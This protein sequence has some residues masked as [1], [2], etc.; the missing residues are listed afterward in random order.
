MYDIL[1]D[2]VIP[3]VLFSTKKNVGW[4]AILSLN[5]HSF[6]PPIPT[7]HGFPIIDTTHLELT[8]FGF[9]L[10]VSVCTEMDDREVEKGRAIG[11]V[12]AAINKY[13]GKINLQGP[14][15]MHKPEKG[16]SD[17]ERRTS[18]ASELHLAKKK[19]DKL[20]DD[21]KIVQSEI[22][23]AELQLLQ[24]KKV[25]RALTARIEGSKSK[26]K[27]Q[28]KAKSIGVEDC[29]YED[30][31]REVEALKRELS[32]LKLDMARA[33]EE[34]L[35]A[36]EEAEAANLTLESYVSSAEQLR[37]EIEEAND[38]EVL[39]ELAKIQARKE[40]AETEAQREEY[41]GKFSSQ[42]EE[43]RK[44]ICI[45]REEMERIKDLKEKLADTNSDIEVLQNELNLIREID[46]RV[47]R[48]NTETQPVNPEE[49]E[50]VKKEL[51]SIQGSAFL[52][53]TIMDA[54]RND[55]KEVMEEKDRMLKLEEETKN[56]I[57]NLNSELHRARDKLAAVSAS[58]AKENLML[59]N[60]S[61]ALED[62]QKEKEGALKE[63]QSAQEEIAS[64]RMEIQKTENG[65][66]VTEEK[67]SAAMQE[68]ASVKSAEAKALKKLKAVAEKAAKSRASASKKKS[69]I[70]ISKFEYN[71]LTGG[72]LAAQEV[73]E[74]KV[75]AAH[76]WAEAMRASEREMNVE[77]ELAEK[78]VRELL[79]QEEQ[80]IQRKEKSL[81]TKES[82]EG[83]VQNL[84]KQSRKSM[85]ENSYSLT[86]ARQAKFRR[87][88]GSPT[89]RR[90][91]TPGSF[92]M[93]RRRM[94]IFKLAKC[95]ASR[96]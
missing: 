25:A 64:V 1:E 16:V 19:I 26:A 33:L 54:I 30:V 75:A 21:A 91:S 49:L 43:T 24:A 38:E 70:A 87:S 48:K 12:K 37:R 46:G 92:T 74:K 66:D 55:L 2:N 36:E 7:A 65:T 29:D 34:K 71:Y 23:Q 22:S 17:S 47:E 82:V 59:S 6:L 11:S 86:P 56:S 85:R 8:D 84:R 78:E 62:L 20:N 41:R 68:L 73:A 90:V 57:K 42:I 31:T 3:P 13:G 15:S 95:L 14:N 93:K 76:L 63:R 79:L 28:N 40:L 58:K 35:R 53:M 81:N 60:L 72:A 52:I 83:E 94:V 77:I 89:A 44:K 4:L 88:A 39:V 5:S 69:T 50:D 27:E 18:K 9:R 61:A 32:K 10:T 80:E 67:L 45:L 96:L 51:D